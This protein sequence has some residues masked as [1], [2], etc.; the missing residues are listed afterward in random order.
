MQSSNTVQDYDRRLKQLPKVSKEMEEE[1]RNL[2]ALVQE[3]GFA[4]IIQKTKSMLRM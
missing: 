4:L 3:Q 1:I 2:T